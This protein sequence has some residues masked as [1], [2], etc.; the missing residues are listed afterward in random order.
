MEEPR[1]PPLIVFLRITAVMGIGF[2]A[3]LGIFLLLG[4]FWLAGIVSLGALVLFLLVMFYVERVA[5]GYH[6]H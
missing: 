5:E 1:V 3:A 2:A 4:G 6:R